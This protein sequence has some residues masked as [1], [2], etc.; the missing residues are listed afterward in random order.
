MPDCMMASPS[1]CVWS[2]SRRQ[3]S[4]GGGTAVS[5][6]RIAPLVQVAA[7]CSPHHVWAR[8][9]VHAPCALTRLDLKAANSLTCQ[10]HLLA[11]CVLMARTGFSSM[12]SALTQTSSGKTAVAAKTLRVPHTAT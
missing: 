10:Q 7:G 12:S 3:S 11:R 6:T 1:A 8:Q 2:F 4:D 9:L 5:E